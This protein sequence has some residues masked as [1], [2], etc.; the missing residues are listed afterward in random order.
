MLDGLVAGS[1]RRADRRRHPRRRAGAVVG[2]FRAA[3]PAVSAELAG[4]AGLL[5][6][7]GVGEL[8]VGRLGTFSLWAD[9][10]VDARLRRVAAAPRR[11][12]PDTGRAWYG[13]ELFARF[14]PYASSG[15]VGRARPAGQRDRVPRVHPAGTIGTSMP[16]GAPP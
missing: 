14:E 10:A 9:L 13:E 1:D 11:R 7:A 3:G 2:A 12:P 16:Y 5:A 8:P 6:A 4:A 15:I